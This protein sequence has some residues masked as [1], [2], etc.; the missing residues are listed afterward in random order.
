MT[1]K[2][3]F[4][5]LGTDNLGSLVGNT[6][7]TGTDFYAALKVN[8]FNLGLGKKDKGFGQKRRSNRGSVKCY[9]F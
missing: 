6:D 7:L 3:G 5:Y 2:L 1:F 4:L 8:P 9:D